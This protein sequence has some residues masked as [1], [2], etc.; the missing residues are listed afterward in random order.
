MISSALQTQTFEVS[1]DRGDGASDSGF[2]D[3]SATS[4]NVTVST[5]DPNGPIRVPKPPNGYYEEEAFECPYC[6]VLLSDI[7]TMKAWKQVYI[8]SMVDNPVLTA[9]QETCHGR[10]EPLYLYVSGLP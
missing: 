5:K 4:Y 3:G 8:P 6:C 2:S 1:A 9:K 7:R 10:L